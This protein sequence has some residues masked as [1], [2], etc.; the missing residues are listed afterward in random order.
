MIIKATPRSGRSG[1]H[2]V[3]QASFVVA[4]VL[5]GL[6]FIGGVIRFRWDRGCPAAGSRLASAVIPMTTTVPSAAVVATGSP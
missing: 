6:V 4:G 3:P 2:I 1:N 5:A